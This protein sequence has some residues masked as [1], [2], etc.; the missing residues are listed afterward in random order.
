M[1][2][3]S[4]YI[5]NENM[6]Y[7][8]L[9]YCILFR[10]LEEKEIERALHGVIFTIKEYEKSELIFH[11]MDRA[12]H[13]GIILDGSAQIEKTFPNGNQV[14]VSLRRRGSLIGPAAVFSQMGRYPCDVVSVEDCKILLIEKNEML[15]LFG[16]DSR[17]LN[18][19]ISVLASSSAMLQSRIELMSYSSIQA[20]IAFYLLMETRRIGNRKV[21]IPES[22]SNWAMMM[23]VSRTSLHREM[24][25][26]EELGLIKYSSPFIEVIDTIGLQKILG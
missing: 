25:K 26:L 17:I 15:K 22:I 20:K 19:F 21:L 24:K 4:S 11:A 23:N 14:N 16:K 18:S 2:T 12:S 7:S 6:D 1:D 3:V 5:Y 13:V 10:S 9:R 8:D